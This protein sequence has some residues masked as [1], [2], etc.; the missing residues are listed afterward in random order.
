MATAT[1]RASRS[2]VAPALTSFHLSR[3]R[4]WNVY[5]I[6]LSSFARSGGVK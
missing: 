6:N 2:G 5:E 4:L 1:H 3:S